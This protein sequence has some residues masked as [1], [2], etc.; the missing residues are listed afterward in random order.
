MSVFAW[1][2]YVQ[3]CF[4]LF[5]SPFSPEGFWSR[6]ACAFRPS[7]GSGS[8]FDREYAIAGR[9][10][11][12]RAGLGSGLLLVMGLVMGMVGV[13]NAQTTPTVSI[14]G[15]G[16]P[17]TEGGTAEF[18]V[19]A[20]PA[21]E[22]DLTVSL[23]IAEWEAPF[24]DFLASGAEGTQTVIITGGTTTATHT[25]ST[26][27]DS[28]DEA[29]N[30][31]TVTITADNSYNV[32]SKASSQVVIE[33][34]DATGV[35]LSTPDTTAAEGDTSD[36]AE[37]TLTFGRGMARSERLDV[38]LQFSGGT[39]GTDFTLT[40]SGSPNGVRLNSATGVVTFTGSDTASATMATVLLTALQDADAT[41]E[42]V[43]VSIGEPKLVS[44][45]NSGGA[46]GSGSGAITISDVAL[47]E[48][49]IAG[50]GTSVT[51]GGTAEFTVTAS[52]APKNDLRV[53]LNV[54]D[55]AASDFLEA[56][57]SGAEGIKVV[58]IPGGQ[59]TAAHT[60]NTQA[61]STDEADG[62][63]TVTVVDGNSYTVGSSSSAAV[64]VKDDDATVVTLRTP[65]ISAT[66]GNASDT[67]SITLTLGRGL[68]TGES[69]AVPLVFANGTLGTEFTLAL[70]GSPDGVTFAANTGE[71]TF[72]GG[73]T[74]SATVAT[75]LLTASDD[76]DTHSKLVTVGIPASDTG[77][78]PVL[79]ATDLSGGAA[80]IDGS[81]G[82]TLIDDDVVPEVLSLR[83][84]DQN[85]GSEGDDGTVLIPF[86]V[87]LSNFYTS[88]VSYRVCATGTATRKT[89]YDFG[90]KNKN[91]ASNSCSSY[92]INPGKTSQVFTLRVHG[93]TDAEED[94]TVTLTVSLD[95]SSAADSNLSLGTS[96]F[97]YTLSNDDPPEISVTLPNKEGV[98]RNDQGQ[99][100]WD[101][102]VTTVDFHV[103]AFP[104]PDAALTTCVRVTETG[105]DRVGAGND[106]VQLIIIPTA[107]T[108]TLPVAWTDTAADD[109][110][111][112]VTVTAV[113]PGTAG[114]TAG[115]GT[116]TV[117]AS[118]AS[119][120]ALVEDDDP[121]EVSLTATDDRMTEGQAT[122]PARMTVSLGRQLYAGET[123]VVPLTLSSAPGS[124]FVTSTAGKGVTLS[125]GATTTPILTFTGS[126]TDTVRTATVKLTPVADRDDGNSVDETVTVKLAS[127]AVLGTTTY[128]TTAGGAAKRH[129][130][131]Y[132][133]AIT[134]AEPGTLSIAGPGSSVMEGGDAEFTVT[135]DPAPE[136][137][138]VVSLTVAESANFGDFVGVDDEG[139]KTVT[140]PANKS[141]ATYT[142]PTVDDNTDEAEGAVT[143]TI[144]TAGND[145]YTVGASSAAVDVEDD[146]ATGVTLSTPDT[147]AAEGDASDTGAITLTLNRGLVRGE[148]LTVPLVFSG[149]VLGTEFT[150]ALSGSPKGV[151]LNAN[152]GVV[153]FS[154]VDP[155]SATAATV[156]L[157]SSDD[158]DGVSESVT[159]TIP[160][161]DTGSAPKLTATG[162]GGGAT[163]SGSGEI[164]L[165]DDEAPAVPGISL[166]EDLLEVNEG[167][168]ATYTMVLDSAPTHDVTVTVT[169]PPTDSAA[170]I[171]VDTAAGTP[172]NQN[173]LTFT[174]A[175]WDRPQTVTV[176]GV[177]DDDSFGTLAN[178]DLTHAVRSQDAA[179]HDIDIASV[180]VTVFDDDPVTPIISI[181]GP[182][183]PVT[184]GDDAVFT[185]TADPTPTRDLT[186]SLSV[187]DAAA[188]DFVASDDEGIRTVTI[189]GGE[190]TAT[191]AVRTQADDTDEAD[192]AVTVTLMEDSSYT[193]SPSAGSAMAD[194]TDDDAATVAV[195]SISADRERVAEGADAAFTLART[196][197]V[198]AALLVR[199]EV[200]ESGAVVARGDKGPR[201][202]TFAAG[203]GTAVL[204]VA[205]VDD[206]ADEPD[207]VVRVALMEDTATPARYG[208]GAASRAAVTVLAGDVSRLRD[209]R[210][211]GAAA[212][213]RRHV[214]RFSQLTSDVA[215]GRLEGGRGPSD[216][217]VHVTN[218]TRK[219][220]AELSFGLRGGWEGWSSL[221]YSRLG[222]TADGEVW[223]AYFGA[224]YRSGDG[225]SVYGMLLGYEP[226]RVT[227]EGVLLDA[228]HVHLGFYG[229]R[230]LSETLIFDGAVG[231]GRGWNDLSMAF[232]PEA[233]TAS[234]RS[235]RLTA[236]GDLTGDFG[237]GSGP[238]RVAPQI[239]L[240][241][242]EE[243]L[244]AFTDSVGGAAEA[245]ELWLA[246]VGFGPRL[247]W[248]LTDSVT[249]MRLRVNLDAH[250]LDQSGARREEVS[251]AFEAGHGWQID[252]RSSLDLSGSVDGLGSGW[253]SSG[254]LG[255]QYQRQIGRRGTLDLSGNLDGREAGE[256]LSGSMGLKYHLDF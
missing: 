52:P 241:Y 255:V 233:L 240:L 175:T 18:T 224:D 244:G 153:T 197:D 218:E 230:R 169:V 183:S 237:W 73:N 53:V 162:L 101:E 144:T 87:D 178:L 76:D 184:E 195:I 217:D 150:L 181:A 88:P 131:A 50:P 158:D 145:S 77:S 132:S 164:T 124:D 208:L 176:T 22:N 134:L 115:S 121:T 200:S 191:Y 147:S 16:S 79:T 203:S 143:V 49:S 99:Q 92:T 190:T 226:G 62:A 122:D 220:Q 108:V 242:A 15:P 95:G 96:S 201:E 35:T 103:S 14:A 198:A 86:N 85:S 56:T 111:S 228:R 78:A 159:V 212:L 13:A 58:T 4:V 133:A 194:I 254:S 236:R 146:D 89:D 215:L 5:R 182:A 231:W 97:T 20:S 26:Q 114:C 32:G 136:N 36:T 229:A 137:D 41:S 21:P 167:G 227:S 207:S 19:T 83:G 247:T 174:P 67:A 44:R 2:R 256:A 72:T 232:G 90:L 221:R 213:L 112:V 80:G 12:G 60:V 189:S 166:S 219:G 23:S 106:G 141:T 31:L 33:D 30:L 94:E 177:E 27:A 39:L 71:V 117:S 209:G 196:G 170:A 98:N 187:A 84:P 172:G 43:T 82:I 45:Y 118:D 25:V 160:A 105:G 163:G 171:T 156:L 188:S 59:T 65:D 57:G 239:G 185:V 253:F 249:H 222:G 180:A 225:R 152:T 140:I 28:T 69:L 202:V 250:N 7:D 1:C 64:D 168:T 235:E 155:V 173:T 251:A 199:V 243:R 24:G 54:A 29:L 104:D 126:G 142:V 135:V 129:A 100:V 107:G 123:I 161:S 102:P 148:N 125:A 211:A 186:V 246:R 216:V 151:T 6:R 55:A 192:G 154:G 205:T 70:S 75:V 130:S 128:G 223:D 93:D 68:V 66:E 42:S 248:T 9:I 48:I 234:Y 51:E 34:D 157:T 46:T 38:P 91:A 10:A 206:G 149:G 179:Y 204:S 210:R 165:V 40:L 74:A 193:V 214:Q 17:V 110:N 37:I 109:R 3:L 120:T 139:S 113:P 238:L 81:G 127:K 252:E 8:F 138:L 245:D 11:C 119:D 116:Y 63:V 47:P 61:D